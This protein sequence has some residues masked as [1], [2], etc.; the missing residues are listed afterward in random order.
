MLK[1]ETF[2][3]IG[4][5]NEHYFTAYQDVDLC[6]ALR[7]L[8]KRNIYCPRAVFVHLESYSR[9]DHYD[10]VDRNLLL[11]RW[12]D[13]IL[14]DPY[15]NRNLDVEACDYSIQAGGPSD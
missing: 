5:F 6:L 3:R 8:G 7:S 2:E 4:G 11:D 12:E 9:R 13:T 1:K 15:Y 14:S 10:F